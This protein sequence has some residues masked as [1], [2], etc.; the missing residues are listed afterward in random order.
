M[1]R[2][3]GKQYDG[4]A[5]AVTSLFMKA[6]CT[7]LPD[8]D[9]FCH[10]TA[11]MSFDPGTGDWFRPVLN[12]KDYMARM[13]K[14][15]MANGKFVL[16]KAEIEKILSLNEGT[17]FMLGEAAF[18]EWDMTIIHKLCSD[19]NAFLICERTKE[20]FL[21]S[22][23]LGCISMPCTVKQIDSIIKNGLAFLF[24]VEGTVDIDPVPDSVLIREM[25]L[26]SKRYPL[27]E[28]LEECTGFSYTVKER[29]AFQHGLISYV[30]ARTKLV[31]YFSLDSKVKEKLSMIRIGSEKNVLSMVT[32]SEVCFL[33]SLSAALKEF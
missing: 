16:E 28:Q 31:E 20:G 32:D 5:Y 10:R 18:P 27:I 8:P 33:N 7:S 19:R 23:P 11:A 14:N 17:Y 30:Q 6:G 29:A 25:L 26:F 2:Y 15:L 1:N 9:C 13:L 3:I 12:W 21:I 24:F 22:N 4:F